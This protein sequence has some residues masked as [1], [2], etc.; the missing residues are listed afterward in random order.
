MTLTLSW[1]IA[2]IVPHPPKGCL[3]LIQ[4]RYVQFLNV[5]YLTGLLALNGQ[6]FTQNRILELPKPDQTSTCAHRETYHPP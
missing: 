6:A 1:G 3:F 2:L 5:E 4:C